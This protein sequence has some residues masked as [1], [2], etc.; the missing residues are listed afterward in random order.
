MNQEALNHGETISKPITPSSGLVSSFFV[1]VFIGMVSINSV[2]YF[3]PQILRIGYNMVK[4]HLRYHRNSDYKVYSTRLNDK[5]SEYYSSSSVTGIPACKNE[6]GLKE[7]LLNGDLIIISQ[8][9]GYKIDKMTYSYPY[10]TKDTKLLLEEIGN[11]F[12]EKISKTRLKN[13]KFIVT[14]M[15]RTMDAVE[16]LQKANSNASPNSPHLNGNAFDI[17]YIRF[18]SNRLIM[19]GNERR[20][21][22]EVL[23]ETIWE[24]KEE[25]KCWATYERCQ[26]CFH[27]VTR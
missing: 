14:S 18:K 6:K 9:K 7:K 27:V 23:A 11:R 20:Y 12:S 4:N 26:N 16:E 3:R 8:G 13:S 1:L 25:K 24:L 19:T 15:T 10:L 22:K 21:L 2:Y 17:T 5:L